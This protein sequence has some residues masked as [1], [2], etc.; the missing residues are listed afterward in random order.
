[1]ELRMVNQ[2]DSVPEIIRNRDE[3]PIY[4]AEV[5]ESA[6]LQP[7][8]EKQRAF[9]EANTESVSLSHLKNDCIIPVFRDNEKTVSHYEFV[10]AVNQCVR[11]DLWRGNHPSRR[12]SEFP[13]KSMAGYPVP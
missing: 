11:T 9:I 12:I 2:R 3:E 1:M 6:P 10:D 5:I 7:K 4:E 13:T 8:V